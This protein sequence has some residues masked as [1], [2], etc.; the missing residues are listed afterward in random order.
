[1]VN[2][3]VIIAEEVS[4]LEWGIEEGM[5]QRVGLARGRLCDRG[6]SDAP[7]APNSRP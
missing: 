2:A 7:T 4:S 6:G 3:N 1:M 5:P